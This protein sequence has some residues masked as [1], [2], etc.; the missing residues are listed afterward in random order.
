[1]NAVH[2]PYD[3]NLLAHNCPTDPISE[4]QAGDWDGQEEEMTEF[5][6]CNRLTS[7]RSEER[8]LLLNRILFHQ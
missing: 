1:M 2:L 3:E 7:E 4:W 6:M 5:E 8:N